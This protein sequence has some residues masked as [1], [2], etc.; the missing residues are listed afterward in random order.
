MEVTRTFDFLQRYKDK[1]PDKDDALAGKVNKEWVK[2]S[3]QDYI[4][5]S[6]YIS[7]GLKELGY[8]AGDK[9]ATINN[10][11]P[12][13]NFVDMGMAQLGII[14]V[15][16]FTTL[17]ND[18]YSDILTHSKAKCVFVSDKAI[19]DKILPLMAEIP[20][21]EKIYSFDEVDGVSSW[22]EVVDLGK[23]KV[24]KH[25]A[26][27]EVI[28]KRI[29]EDD[30]V[31]L[32]YTSGTTGTP[33][34][35]MLS[36]KNLVSNAK[37][38]AGVFKL[39]SNHRYLGILPICHVGERMG[40]YQTQYSGCSI[41]YAENL[42]TIADDL[43]DV[44]PHGFG[45]V[46]RILEKVYDKIINKGEKL[47]GVKK[48]LFFWALN[49]GLD[50]QIDKKNGLW[51]EMKLGIANKI[52]FSKWREAMGGNVISIGVGGAAL[53]PRLEK[54]FWSAKIKLLNMYGL[55]ETSPI[56]T[57][58]RAESPLVQLGSV[59]AGV[60][61]VDI[62]IAEDGEILCK[63]HN[64]M[65]GYYDNEEATKAAIDADGWFHTGDIG[66]LDQ[67][68]FL[69]ITDRKKELFKLSNGKYVS[70]QMVENVFKESIY[71]D[72]LMAI[73]EGEKFA[74]AIISPNFDAL[75]TWCKENGV[76]T[77]DKTAIIEDEKVKALFNSVVKELN[78]KVEK[79]EQLKRFR[80]V[81]DEWTPES[82]ELSPTLKLKRRVIAEKYK[83]IIA[84]IFNHELEDVTT[85]K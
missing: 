32:I 64:V 73:G 10:N 14:H 53:Q 37:V 20:T 43:K 75:K 67:G 59:G 26:Q 74:S 12:E 85:E 24:E 51:Y 58:N 38:A 17:S 9:I 5:Y 45:A 60:E 66:V 82:G 52:I 16:I 2:Y 8:V 1:F 50:Y 22:K 39:Q 44:K 19:A 25:S 76:D 27:V 49:L 11:R 42:G 30:C 40:N 65:L 28:K 46:P 56:I 21:L 7:F 4:N 29:S 83:H 61:G 47:T 41:Y 71:I 3:S 70:P 62:K 69:R 78:P 34:G 13:W 81:V 35:V 80:I 48:K 33:K 79:D 18:G 15:P 6:N 68:R 55:T 23:T 57:I 84:D 36:H 77:S 54:V 31:T 72:Q 63:G